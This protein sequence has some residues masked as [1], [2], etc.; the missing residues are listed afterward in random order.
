MRL[1][2]AVEIGELLSQHVADV[3][4][5][6]QRR[7]AEAAPHAKVT[8]VPPDRMHLT[9]RFIGEVDDDKAALV[10]E[11]L[12]PPFP[13][14][15]FSLTLCG[16]GTFPR[17]GTPRVVWIGVTEGREALL[18][19]ERAV[20]AR[21]QSLGIPEEDRAFSPHLTLGRVREP[22]RLKAPRLVDGLTERTVGSVRVDA[23]T[24]FHSKLS[25]KGPT[26]TPLLR[27]VL[28]GP[29]GPPPERDVGPA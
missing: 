8:W 29:D 17:G 2:V 5:E 26:Y 16:V 20:S 22:G 14:S 9:I 27:S 12:A 6:L 18:A 15:S 7:A 1:F 10:R 4:R 24:L 23:I 11:A 3:S 28:G 21:L 25:P 19:I 13:L